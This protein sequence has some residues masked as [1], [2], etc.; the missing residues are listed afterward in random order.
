MRTGKHFFLL[1][2]L[3]SLALGC[4]DDE[5]TFTPPSGAGG[6]GVAGQG[7]GGGG[8]SGGAS[9]AGQ[10]GGGQAGA[11][12]PGAIVEVSFASKVGVLLDE[13]DGEARERAA[14]E[15][16]GRPATFWQ[17][18]AARQVETATYRL[19]YRN[20]YH[21][22][23]R[24]QL[25]LPPR[26]LWKIEVGKPV[27]EQIEGHDY[28]AAPVTFAS[29]LLTPLSSPGTADPALAAPGG[30]VIESFVLPVDPELLLERTGMACMNESYFP[31]NSVDTENA[32]SFFDDTCTA[33]SVGLEGCHA[34]EPYPTES[35]VEAVQAR[36][37]SVAVDV[38]FRRVPW[39]AARADAIRVGKQRAGGAQLR[40]RAE[41]LEDR[42][43][44]WR[45]FPEFSC[46]I[47]E[48]CVGGSGW[49]RLL[50]FTAT[51]E[52]TGDAPVF[53]GDVGPDSPPVKNN[54]VSL[55]PCHNHMHFNH[56]GR[57]T[58]GAGDKQL[59][60]KRAFCV[61]STSRYF[62]NEQTPLE[63]PYSCT[64]QGTQIGW[65]D[66]YI[67]G[68]DCQWV[69]VTPLPG[70]TTG[71]L[72]FESNPDQFLCEGK[73]L[74]DDEGNPQ[75]EP[76]SFTNEQGQIESRH[77]CEPFAD[78]KD[79]NVASTEVTLPAEG[80]MVTEPCN[81][82]LLGEKRNCGFARVSSLLSC[83]AG[84]PAKVTCTRSGSDQPAAVRV[85]EASSEHG[86]L[87]CVFRDALAVGV[88]GDTTL[89]LDVPCPAPRGG[90]EVGGLVGVYAAPLIPGEEIGQITCEV[91]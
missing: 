79:D 86:A 81:R 22:E 20:Y 26:E 71:Q 70:G 43:I 40:V 46:A 75:F 45:Y 8:G 64:F 21:E 6:S 32:R 14:K 27:R 82:W 48:G 31:P 30:E 12:D 1:L 3:G 23:E 33:D 52:N 39:D 38:L 57:F 2:A 69:D 89:E 55:S 36:V 44:V 29:A 66:D 76:T 9:G 13:L 24:W 28:V 53:L 47:A 91:K 73:L 41:G 7:A 59:G 19:I 68:L 63:H 56:Y 84:K 16:L 60:S 10:G 18:Q 87:P 5:S 85:C 54:M 25:P 58:F 4:T 15:A 34:Q 90:T 80:G 88:Q 67:A 51:V 65:G 49:R 35:C 42:R 50:Q 62:N 77:R 11:E 17:E 83:A 72:T 74:R 37:G 78:A 61:E